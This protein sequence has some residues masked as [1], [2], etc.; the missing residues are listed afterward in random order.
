VKSGQ[1]YVCHQRTAL[2]NPHLS[3]SGPCSTARQQTDLRE[4]WL[5]LMS[6]RKESVCCA[7]ASNGTIT[8][9]GRYGSVLAREHAASQWIVGIEADLVAPAP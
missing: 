1:T 7:D 9:D 6:E 4:R 5:F 2:Y 8:G 3:S